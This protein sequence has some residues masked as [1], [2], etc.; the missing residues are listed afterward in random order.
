MTAGNP[1]NPLPPNAIEPLNFQSS[2]SPPQQHFQWP[3]E[4]GTRVFS[5]IMKTFCIVSALAAVAALFMIT[6]YIVYK[7]IDGFFV[8]WGGHRHWSWEL[9]TQLPGPSDSPFGMKSQFIGTAIL[10][11]LASIVGIPLGL[12]CGIYLA[13]YATKGWFPKTIRTVVEIL[14]SVP[15]IVI[16][17][18]AFELFVINVPSVQGWT[19]KLL[20]GLHD[21]C[22]VFFMGNFSGYAGAL[23]LAFIMAPIVAVVSEEML[24]LVPHSYREAS[25]GVGASRFQTL[26]NVVL[27]SAAAGI[28]TGIMLAIARI[29][30][31]TAPLIFTTVGND[32]LIL[33]PAQQMPAVT[34]KIWLYS[35]SADPGWIKQAWSAMLVVVLAVLFFNTLVRLE[36]WRRQKKLQK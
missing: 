15:S 17:V 35:T 6:G 10:V 27:P 32:Q 33:N 24:R 4:H 18:V 30:G 29:A 31:E 25:V 20:Q 2:G 13:E 26:V 8:D 9:F 3:K 11:G 19:G 22:P 1:G 16:G 34:L 5:V 7:G 36:L 21:V 28:I 14:A 23:A 12:L